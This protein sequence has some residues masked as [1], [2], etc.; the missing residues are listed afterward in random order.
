MSGLTVERRHRLR[1]HKAGKPAFVM[2]DRDKAV[3][4]LVADYGVVSSEEIG[5]LTRG[6]RQT[7]LRRLQCLYHAGYLDRPRRQQLIGN[8]PLV[9]A[10]GLKGATL[11]GIICAKPGRDWAEKNRKMQ[12][13]YIEHQLMISRFRAALVLA[14]TDAGVVVE[15]WC[16]G[17]E[18][19]DSVQVEHADF[20]ERIPV[21]PDAYAILRILSEPDGRNRVH[22][23][24]EADRS[25]MTAKRFL[26]KLRGYWHY[27][28]CGRLEEKYGIKNVLVATV[29]KTQDRASNLLSAAA[30]IDAPQHRGLRMFMFAAED[31]F[32]VVSPDNILK[33]IWRVRGDGRLH[34]LTE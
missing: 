15:H 28:R 25:T 34:S 22:L 9:Y 14:G 19:W 23:F 17:A 26:T 29:T 20:A 7:L 30:Q 4:Q 21:A 31:Q 6:S 16:Q 12:I 2:Q 18:L 8:G 33:A 1:R 10:L 32:S 3:V 24:L 5:A 11:P 27:W 13:G